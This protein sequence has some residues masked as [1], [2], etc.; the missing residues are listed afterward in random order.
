MQAAETSAVSGDDAK[1]Q[2]WSDKR[3]DLEMHL[4][5]QLG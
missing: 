2:Q 4:S 5:K 3:A 1:T